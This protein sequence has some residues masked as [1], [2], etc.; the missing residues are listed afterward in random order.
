MSF[1]PFGLQ[2]VVRV[3]KSMSLLV[4][5]QA[6]VC[7]IQLQGRRPICF[8]DRVALASRAGLSPTATSRVVPRFGRGELLDLAF[9]GSRKQS[10]APVGAQ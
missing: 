7:D 2:Y 6:F 5:D 4:L 1:V 10:P 8:V 3:C 9:W